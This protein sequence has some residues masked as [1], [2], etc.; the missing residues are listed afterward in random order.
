[1]SS[2]LVKRQQ[3]LHRLRSNTVISVDQPYFGSVSYACKKMKHI[4]VWFILLVYSMSGMQA[5]MWPV[6]TTLLI[7]IQAYIFHKRHRWTTHNNLLKGFMCRYVVS[8]KSKNLDC[9]RGQ[10]FLIEE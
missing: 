9:V 7:K 1:M 10:I 8:Y 3:Q 4:F 6:W 5:V 2:M